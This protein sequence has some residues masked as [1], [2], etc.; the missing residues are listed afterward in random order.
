MRSLIIEN[1]VL[2]AHQRLT[3]V[4]DMLPALA[5]ATSWTVVSATNGQ[6]LVVERTMRWDA[7]GT[8][9]TPRR[10]RPARPR[11]WYFAEGSQ[12]FFS[13]YFLLANPHDGQRRATVTYLPRER[14]AR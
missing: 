11:S 3:V 10:R 8:A 13:T 9:R 7:T 12:G 14:A 2:L 1:G 5:A 6:P 4:V